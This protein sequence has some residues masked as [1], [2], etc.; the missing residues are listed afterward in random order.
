MSTAARRRS[1][2]YSC[3][4]GPLLPSAGCVARRGLAWPHDRLCAQDHYIG[5]NP[6]QHLNDQVHL[7]LGTAMYDLMGK[8]VGQPCHTLFGPQCRGYVPVSSWFNATSPARMA[9]A[10]QYYAAMGHTYSRT[11]CLPR[12]LTLPATAPGRLAT[13]RGPAC[14]QSSLN[15][16][17][18]ASLS[19]SASVLC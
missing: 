2:R 10:V 1:R 7:G 9:E 11:P 4:P 5:T 3:A 15:T 16:G 13:C 14:C 17:L 12:P 19:L 8:A 6:F 18:S